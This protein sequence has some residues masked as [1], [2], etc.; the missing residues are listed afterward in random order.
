[1]WEILTDSSATLAFQGQFSLL[2]VENGLV[3]MALAMR[4]I[5][6]GIL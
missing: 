3:K 5:T 1:M 6:N 4:K 2:K